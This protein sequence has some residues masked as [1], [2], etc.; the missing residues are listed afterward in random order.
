MQSPS[1]AVTACRVLDPEALVTAIRDAR[2]DACQ[3]SR[4]PAPSRLGRVA[5][6][7]VCLDFAAL[8]PAMLFHGAMPGDRYTL[9]FVLR[10]PQPGRSFNFQTEH[11][12]GYLGL[13]PPGGILD[14]YTPPDYANAT[15]TVPVNEF[16]A[17]ITRRF[18]ELPAQLLERGVAVRVPPAADARLRALLAAIEEA[19]WD[20]AGPLASPAVRRQLEPVMLEQFLAAL[21][22]GCETSMVRP[23]RRAAGRHQRL[24]QARE[25]VAA[26]LHQP[27]RLDDLCAATGLTQRGVQD[28]FHDLLGLP[29]AAFL[30]H[31][32]LHRARRALLE[33]APG[34]GVVKQAALDSGFLHLGRFARDYRTLF[35]EPP[36]DTA[37]RRR[38]H[39][40]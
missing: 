31:Q 25:L 33:T 26:R 19:L 2:L 27:L 5:C 20:P 32:R 13:F 39:A 11:G 4:R 38:G 28:L 30:R 15:L 18:P 21:R 16:H 6:P 36:G 35:G 7:G 40:P 22:S 34:P 14:A 37:R 10:C 17:A 29:P 3:V 9:I 1:P 8:G 23:S 24:R 12:A